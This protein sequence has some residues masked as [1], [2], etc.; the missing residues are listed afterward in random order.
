MKKHTFWVYILKSQKDGLLYIW[1]TTD[2]HRRLTEH[3]NGLSDATD[4]S[5]AARSSSGAIFLAMRRNRATGRTKPR[6]TRSS[7][8]AS[9][10]TTF[11]Q[12]ILPTN[13]APRVRVRPGCGVSCFALFASLVCFSSIASGQVFISQYYEGTSNNKWIELYNGGTNSVNLGAG[14]YRLGLRAMTH[15]KTGRPAPL[16]TIHWL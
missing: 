12:M 10:C 9:F 7:T 13:K 3:I 4:G 14:G 1:F 16:L 6:G 8:E 5:R 11:K 15:G 2:L